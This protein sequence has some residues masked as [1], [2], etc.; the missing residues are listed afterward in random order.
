M[1][2]QGFHEPKNIKLYLTNADD[3]PLTLGANDT[4]VFIYQSPKTWTQTF[5]P[6]Q[7]LADSGGN[8]INVI[9]PAPST[10]NQSAVHKVALP[11]IIPY[12]L[13][14]VTPSAFDVTL[15]TGH[16]DIVHSLPRI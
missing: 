4:L 5:L 8:Y 11:T 2:L 13:K 10:I 6:A 7:V 1:F 12:E 16:F 3:T 15:L 9:I 14:Y